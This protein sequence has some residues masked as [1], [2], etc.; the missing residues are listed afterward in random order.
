MILQF[1]IPDDNA[2]VIAKAL[3]NLFPKP[4]DS[5]YTDVQWTRECIRRWICT[6]VARWKQMQLVDRSVDYTL[7]D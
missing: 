4:D 7:V 5:S 2:S 6:Q 3:C 1:N